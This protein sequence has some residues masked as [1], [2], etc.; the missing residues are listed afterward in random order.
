MSN[1][2]QK[3]FYYVDPGIGEKS[4]GC[5]YSLFE[6]GHDVEIFIHPPRGYEIAD[7]KVEPYEDSFYDGKIVAQYRKVSLYSRLMKHRRFF[8]LSLFWGSIC[9]LGFMAYRYVSSLHDPAISVIP[10]PEPPRPVQPIDSTIQTQGS[11][12]PA[13]AEAVVEKEK[14]PKKEA[15]VEKEPK[16][17]VVVEKESQKEAIVEVAK[18]PTKEVTEE[19]E[20]KKEGVLKE[21][22][23]RQEFWTLIHKRDP[24]MDSYHNLYVNNKGKVKCEEYEYLRLVILDSTKAYKEWL[25]KLKALPDSELQNINTIT[26]LRDALK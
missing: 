3:K 26:A 6:D 4:R 18:E 13:I 15:I 11:D 8:L 10:R 7:F 21:D 20:P 12:T 23:F 14:E 19:K 17:E 25:R 16:K 9:I 22:Q 1:P 2:E 24:K 5:P